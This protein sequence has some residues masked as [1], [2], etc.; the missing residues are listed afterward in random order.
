MSAKS[1]SQL[2]LSFLICGIATSLHTGCKPKSDTQSQ[3]QDAA[4]GLAQH[5]FYRC[6]TSTIQKNV[7]YTYQLSAMNNTSQEISLQIESAKS[8]TLDF[9]ELKKTTTDSWSQNAK[10]SVKLRG[11]RLFDGLNFNLF[12]GAGFTRPSF[13][14]N[15]PGTPRRIDSRRLAV[16]LA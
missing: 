3:V 5:V 11:V 4:M 9:S 2:K 13:S 14:E 7:K 15:Q 10:Y 12:V 8:P 16:A 6:T 1:A